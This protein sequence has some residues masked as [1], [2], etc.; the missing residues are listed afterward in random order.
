MTIVD[1]ET[2]TWAPVRT[3]GRANPDTAERDA[4]AGSREP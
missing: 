3:D 2:P 1:G 4:A